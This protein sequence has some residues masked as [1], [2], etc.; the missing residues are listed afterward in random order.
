[1]WTWISGSNVE[2]AAGVYGTLGTAA[3]GNV[4]GAR[5]AASTWIDAAGNLW[6]FGGYGYDSA[7][8]VGKLNDLLRY[9]PGSEQWPCISGSS[10][11]NAAGV[12]GTLRA[13]AAGN[14]PGAREAASAWIASSGELWMFGGYGYDSTGGVGYL[15]DLWQYSPSTGLWTWIGGSS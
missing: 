14:L 4:P 1:Q 6:L 11:E 15:N 13:A 12:Y 5:Y 9:T 10:G 7:G 2:N 3:A 8:S